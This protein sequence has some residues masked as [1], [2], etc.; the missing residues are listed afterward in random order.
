M[1]VAA[2]GR[3][4]VSEGGAHNRR[5]RDVTTPN[6]LP[7]ELTSFVGREPQLAELRRLLH[8][9]R[10]ITLTGPG[11]S[12]K[13]RL[14]VRLAAGSLERY[15]DGVWL[16]DLAP[17]GDSRLLEHTLASACG[18]KQ[19]TH[20]TAA[21]P[22]TE[23]LA[24]SQALIVFDGCEHLVDAT[25]ELASRL[26][27]SCARL[28]IVVTSREPL[29]VAGELIWRTPSLTIPR[30]EDADHP[31]LLM[32]S[33]AARLFVDRARLA[34]PDFVL[35]AASARPVAQICARLEGIPLA[36]ELAAGLAGVMTLPDI[37]ERLG[38]RFRLLTGGGRASLPRHQTLRQAVDWSYGL[39]SVNEQALFARLAVF[40]GGFD[41]AAAEAVVPGDPIAVEDVLALL[42]R[43]VNKSLV[44]AEPTRPHLTRYRMLD[45][46]REYAL[47]KLQQ[48]GE[49]EWRRR[50]ADYFTEWSSR[51]TDELSLHDQ[52]ETL[53]AIDEE[54][55]N[56][57]LALEW[58][59]AEQPDNALRIASAMGTYWFMRRSLAEGLDWLERAL[60]LETV[61][62]DTRATALVAAARLTRRRGEFT[63]SL[64][65]A[66]EAAAIARRL[67]L[68]SVLAQA[69]NMQGILASHFGETEKAAQVFREALEVAERT[70]N[71][72]RMVASLNNLAM[73]ESSLGDQHAALAHIERSVQL[74]DEIGD[75]FLKANV[76][77][78]V[79]R[80]LFRL[81]Q[82]DHAAR[83]WSEALTT[84]LEFA[85][86]INVAD[87][88]DGVALLEAAR[89]ENVRALSLTAAA[90]S[91]RK[92]TGARRTVEWLAEV[93][94]SMARAR[95]RLTPAVAEEAR[96]QGATMTLPEAV[97]YALRQQPADRGDSG[98]R[99]TG[100]EVEVARLVAEGKTNGEVAAQLRI[101]ERTVDAHVEH[102]RNKL[103]LRTRTQIALWAHERLR[104]A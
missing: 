65:Y 95:A 82:F 17:I 39:L 63:A 2:N 16:V 55:P 59:L 19:D 8:R 96:R 77:D 31:E 50:H 97:R 101:S 89:G 79:G 42:S 66:D 22:L 73:M 27:R 57:R 103:G 93:E 104:S 99:L 20:S 52:V 102:I 43:L 92:I 4:E 72:E 30:P 15:P 14:A 94:D 25:A 87:V 80:I 5:S 84:S 29:G 3:I 86:T 83:A 69:V 56:V 35:G 36:I 68:D 78:T 71:R 38:K 58:S 61:R 98:T 18:L 62:L 45:T 81:G 10:L 6:N 40:A 24:K 13:T 100:R 23:A 26:L 48:S 74:A 85:D 11:G 46:I 1:S 54:Q 51:E 9:S 47:E 34:R 41:L 64:A 75:R 88:L 12:G 32:E 44:I 91:M 7:A 37:L 67:D 70:G 60:Q 90:E 49:A 21:D 76:Q 33:E 53:A 28:G